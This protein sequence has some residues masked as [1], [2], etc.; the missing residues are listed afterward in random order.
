MSDCKF[1]ITKIKIVSKVNMYFHFF[2]FFFLEKQHFYCTTTASKQM[3]IHKNE[4]RNHNSLFSQFTPSIQLDFGKCV[5]RLDELCV[6]RKKKML[7]RSSVCGRRALSIFFLF[8]LI[9]LTVSTLSTHSLVK[10][11]NLPPYSTPTLMTANKN[12]PVPVDKSEQSM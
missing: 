8:K 11:F 10:F 3:S 7:T 6:N 2:F 12:Q 4:M 9:L 1:K 5:Q